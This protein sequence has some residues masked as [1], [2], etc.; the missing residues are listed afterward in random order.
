MDIRSDLNNRIVCYFQ[1]I[2]VNRTVFHSREFQNIAVY[3]NKR[4]RVFVLR[5]VRH[6]QGEG[7]QTVGSNRIYPRLFHTKINVSRRSGKCD[8]MVV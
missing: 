7:K 1:R 2:P 6:R 5:V 3:P 4:L 8:G